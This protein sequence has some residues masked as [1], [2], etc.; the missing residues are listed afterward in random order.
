MSRWLLPLALCF[1][2]TA[3]VLPQSGG[4]SQ[5]RQ[6]L[7]PVDINHA[8]LDQLMAVPGITAVWAKRILRNRPYRTKQDLLDHGIVPPAVYDRIRDSII[9]HR[10]PE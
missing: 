4:A 6:R 9:A 3:A 5:S 7:A 2:L 8:T 1:T 10:S